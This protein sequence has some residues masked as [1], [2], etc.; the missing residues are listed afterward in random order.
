MGIGPTWPSSRSKRASRNGL[1]TR[2][3]GSFSTLPSIDR[4]LRQLV[5]DVNLLE[6]NCSNSF[7]E[8]TIIVA[9]ERLPQTIDLSTPAVGF[10]PTPRGSS[11]CSTAPSTPVSAPRSRS[12]TRAPSS[13][14]LSASSLSVMRPQNLAQSM[15]AQQAGT[16]EMH[17]ARHPKFVQGC[18]HCLFRR[19]ASSWQ[20]AMAYVN[21]ITK[22]RVT[23]LMRRPADA[24]PF[25]LGCVDC[26]AYALHLRET[27][28]SKKVSDENIF[29]AS[30][31]Q[32]FHN[33]YILSAFSLFPRTH[34][35]FWTLPKRRD[36]S[37]R[38]GTSKTCIR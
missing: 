1:G 12:T 33:C 36:K 30:T 37:K 2:D 8:V 13:V 28:Q 26:A 20:E 7:V 15:P 4:L 27:N 29:F 11:T 14:A 9:K 22:Q 17:L 6:T 16:D 31:S 38:A 24:Q 5:F 21:P 25:S 10:Q 34:P 18:S 19:H 35:G 23:T 32:L 3:C